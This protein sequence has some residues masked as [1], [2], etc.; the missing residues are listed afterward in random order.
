MAEVNTASV[1]WMD[2]L[3]FETMTGSGH[4]GTI[5][6]NAPGKPGAG[7]GP[8]EL[9][10][11]GLA[12]CTG[13]DVVDILR[14]KRVNVKGLEVRVEGTRAETHPMTYTSIDVTYIVRGQDIPPS[15]VEQAI[16]LSEEKF[17]SVGVMLAQTARIHSR[18]EILAM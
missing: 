14:K 11:V 18:Y 4:K 9:V 2:G 12:G 13:M 8:M 16:R 17:C 5:D 3:R 10:L 15:A 1:K 6:S 7:P